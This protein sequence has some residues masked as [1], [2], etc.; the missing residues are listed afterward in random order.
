MLKPYDQVPS[1]EHQDEAHGTGGRLAKEDAAALLAGRSTSEQLMG[2]AGAEDMGVGRMEGGP[3]DDGQPGALVRSL[4]FKDGLG[5]V[6]GIMIGSGIFS[7]PGA[8]LASAGASGSVL[9]A[10][11]VSGVLVALA[12]MS[13][14]ELGASMPSAGGDAEYLRQAYGEPASFLFAWTNFWV[15]K[16]GSQAII[17]TIFGEYVES[18]LR[19]NADSEARTASWLATVLSCGAIIG[20][21]FINCL[22]VRST[23]NLQNTL[24]ATKLGMVGVVCLLGLLAPVYSAEAASVVQS[25]LGADAFAHFTITGFG[26][27]MIACLWAFDG[28]A[29]LGSLAEE[30]ESPQ[31]QLPWIIVSS[32][33]I[34]AVV[35]I[36]VNVAYFCVLEAQAVEDSSAVAIA[37]ANNLW[38]NATACKATAVV[39]ALGVS[40]STLGSCN[41]SI[42]T[43][44]S[45]RA[46]L[47]HELSHDLSS[48]CPGGRVFYACSR[49]GTLSMLPCL[50]HLN[51]RGAPSRALIMQG[52]WG[53]VLLLLPGSSFSSLLDYFG[54]ASWLF[55]AFTGSATII[56]RRQAP[57]MPRPFLMPLYPLPP[58]IVIAMSL[59]LV[60][61]SLAANPLYC[62]IALVFVAAGFPV[63]VLS[64]RPQSRCH[65]LR[66]ALGCE[67]CN[68]RDRHDENPP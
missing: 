17:A 62:T 20:L 52:V 38:T 47:K 4:T 2:A 3:K 53:V 55:Y 22:G 35:Y 33:A 63:Y 67:M 40:V 34:V 39:I 19:G 28:W 7:S 30:L 9:L 8:A 31:T 37:F 36:F 54:P 51:K 61:T 48:F 21:T 26:R 42:M 50:N 43:G 6:I 64:K 65:A 60:A 66:R 68:G 24:T 49:D 57:N 29:D 56:L 44:K 16:P 14:G 15:L 58:I 41:G 45:L 13:Y 11:A 23:A 25:N 32:V 10:W 5:V 59:V 18:V 12:S 1:H 27:A 46:S